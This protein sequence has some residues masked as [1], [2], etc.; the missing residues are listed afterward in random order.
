MK[1]KLAFVRNVGIKLAIFSLTLMIACN[2]K[3][4]GILSEDKMAEILV[5]LKVGEA[6]VDNIYVRGIDSSRIIY[7][8]LEEKVLK[9]H[10]TDTSIYNLS[11]KYYLQNKSKMLEIFN[12]SE[13]ILDELAEKATQL[14]TDST[15]NE[16]PGNNSNLQRARE[17]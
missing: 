1:I 3:P 9:K 17:Y 2:S 6:H 16:K 8:H 12:K 7:N 14:N 5:D 15:K 4:K 13:K 11:Y 10:K